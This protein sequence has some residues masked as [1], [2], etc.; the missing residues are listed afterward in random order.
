MRNI[1]RLAAEVRDDIGLFGPI[2]AK[3]LARWLGIR[4]CPCPYPCEGL[5]GDRQSAIAVYYGMAGEACIQLQVARA[6]CT[7][8]L[9]WAG[10]ELPA[11]WQVEALAALLCGLDP[12]RAL[13]LL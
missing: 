7:Y 13:V 11:D 6:A 5:V 4:L 8:V 10:V 1:E 12:A 9:I 2:D 3:Q